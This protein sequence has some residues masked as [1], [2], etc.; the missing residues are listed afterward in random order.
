MGVNQSSPVFPLV[1][2][3]KPFVGNLPSAYA[4]QN[5]KELCVTLCWCYR[6]CF[7][8]H[9]WRATLHKCYSALES[10]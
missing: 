1:L 10:V 6:Y 8:Q 2:V 9:R 7:T 5:L 3:H 4:S